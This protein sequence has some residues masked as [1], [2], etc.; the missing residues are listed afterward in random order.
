MRAIAKLALLSIA[1]A[2]VACVLG[3]STEPAPSSAQPPTV[4]RYSGTYRDPLGAEVLPIG[5][6]LVRN[7]VTDCSSFSVD[8]NANDPREFKIRCTRDGKTFV[9]YLVRTDVNT[10]TRLS[11]DGS[12]PRQ[13]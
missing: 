3:C 8:A 5:R 1:G 11:E 6:A 13:P 4:A 7:Q 10:M 12:L 9:Y 2:A